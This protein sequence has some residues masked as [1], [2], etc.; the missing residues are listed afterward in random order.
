MPR[1]RLIR[2]QLHEDDPMRVTLTKIEIDADA[3]EASQVVSAALRAAG[4]TSLPPALD[5][6]PPALPAAAGVKRQVGR[7][8]KEAAGQPRRQRTQT[9]PAASTNRDGRHTPPAEGT[10]AWHVLMALSSKGPMTTDELLEYCADHGK[11]TTYLTIENTIY[12]A[13]NR[14]GGYGV[15]KV[16]GRWTLPKEG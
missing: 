7:P 1:A 12:A 11:K 9:R 6:P 15:E 14:R 13:L 8:R 10:I 5:S 16:G 2:A 3:A 4:F